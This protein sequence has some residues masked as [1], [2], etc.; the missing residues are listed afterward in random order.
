MKTDKTG[1]IHIA[2]CETRKDDPRGETADNESG[3]GHEEGNVTESK[4]KKMIIHDCFSQQGI[5]AGEIKTQR[6][7]KGIWS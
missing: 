2:R 4:E 3:N 6:E 7:R 5:D 1:I